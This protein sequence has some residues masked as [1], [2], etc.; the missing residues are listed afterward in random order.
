MQQQQ[1]AEERYKSWKMCKLLVV[2]VIADF[3]LQFMNVQQR[4]VK[5]SLS[6]AAVGKF[7]KK[8]LEVIPG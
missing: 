3:F 8:T 6:V 4:K 5:Y 1:I 2:F 7:Q